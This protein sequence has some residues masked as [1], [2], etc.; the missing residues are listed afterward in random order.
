MLCYA[1]G[2]CRHGR[3]RPGSYPGGRGVTSFVYTF[4]MPDISFAALPGYSTSMPRN[5][6]PRRL[7]QYQS[8]SS[9]NNVI[10]RT[11][12]MNQAAPANTEAAVDVD[13]SGVVAGG[14]CAGGVL[15]PAVPMHHNRIEVSARL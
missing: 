4:R 13:K 3:H 9:S 2:V 12:S 8:S 14:G 7:Q 1:R 6:M 11:E 15:G 5:P 10:T